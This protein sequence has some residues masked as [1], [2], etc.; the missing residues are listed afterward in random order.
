M[1]APPAPR[2]HI[3]GYLS[4][5]AAAGHPAG[6]APLWRCEGATSTAA[7]AA[8]RVG[9]V[10][11][12]LAAALAP[13]ARVA[14]LARPTPAALEALLAV[15]AAGC[16]AAPLN[17]RWAPVDAAAAA[18]LLG[19]EAV[20][21][22]AALLPLALAALAAAAAP[23]LVLLGGDADFAG[24]APRAALAAARAAGA[25][26]ASAAAL[27]AGRPPRPPTHSLIALRWAPDDAA[28]AVFTSGTSGA[29][30]AA[31]LSHAGLD[32]QAHAKAARQRT[33]SSDLY[34][35]AAPL[36]HVGGL[37]SALAALAAGAAHAFLPAYSPAAALAAIRA[38][39]ATALIAVPATAADF[40]A[41]AAPGEA[42]PS[43]R[44]LLVG[45]GSLSPALA[46]RLAALFPRAEILTAYGLTEGGSSLTFA[47]AG[48]LGGGVSGGGGGAY[49]GRPPPGI[50]LGV[51]PAGL[52]DDAPPSSSASVI[53][54]SSGEGEV[55]TRG[56][57]LM[58]RYWAAPVATSAARLPG[59]W[60][61]TGDL[62][63]L[64]RGGGLWLAGR[65]RD[66]VRSGG[67]S[68]P[69]WEV[70]AAAAAHAGVA[71]AAVV[72]VPDARLGEAVGCAVELAPGWRW[73]GGACQRPPPYGEKVLSAERLAPRTLDG[74]A[75]QA[76]CRAAGLAPFK[77]P[78]VFLRVGALPRGATGK[79]AKAELR[80][81]LA[82]AAAALGAPRARL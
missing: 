16:V 28:V 69:A 49:V 9:A 80:A 81:A 22:D 4:A 39:G 77:L 19:A 42:L 73:A 48:E 33:S 15:A 14:I 23:L 18:A 41:A 82:A 31:L 60:L 27:A 3:A 61:R 29:P 70:E 79:V 1:A 37:A 8:A 10:A 75:L 24:A 72:P 45:A 40:A 59:G 36:F 43:V 13:G 67:E 78:R 50:E 17:A 52:S 5:A 63:R 51:V 54:A 46:A 11:A 71:A 6:G 38:H 2:P 26:V 68:V 62:G 21:T 74:A 64:E 44:A 55:V 7:E 66:V 76:H 25:R 57:H 58:L 12:A 32:F 20:V 35:H 56:P 34:L 53:V 65:A 30:R 47:A